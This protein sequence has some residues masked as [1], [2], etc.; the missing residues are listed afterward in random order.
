MLPTRRWEKW[1]P[2]YGEL[3]RD[4]ALLE[5]FVNRLLARVLPPDQVSKV[6]SSTLMP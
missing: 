6:S 3:A 5:D 1:H 4:I 2:R